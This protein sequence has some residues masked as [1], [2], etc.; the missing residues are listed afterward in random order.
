MSEKPRLCA[1]I[2]TMDREIKPYFVIFCINTAFCSNCVV[3]LAEFWGFCQGGE[4]NQPICM[5]AL[6]LMGLGADL[7]FALW[8][9][10]QT[11]LNILQ[12]VGNKLQFTPY[13]TVLNYSSADSP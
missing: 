4:Q 12:I 1:Y 5:W 3:M 8:Y 7:S 6:V 2:I 11:S 13:K 10:Y 9:L